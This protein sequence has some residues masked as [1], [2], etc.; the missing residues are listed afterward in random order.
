MVC[1]HC[2]TLRTMSRFV[3]L[4]SSA[5]VLLDRAEL[6]NL[7][8]EKLSQLFT[9]RPV[10]L[11]AFPKSIESATL[12]RPWFLFPLFSTF[13][14]TM[15]HCFIIQRKKKLALPLAG[16]SAQEFFSSLC[17]ESLDCV[18]IQRYLLRENKAFAFG[19]T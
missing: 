17:L 10:S 4:L 12:T 14:L 6:D 18:K 16:Y 15:R 19:L 5:A 3:I 2:A 9:S 11:A 13:I 1:K 7:Q 8:E